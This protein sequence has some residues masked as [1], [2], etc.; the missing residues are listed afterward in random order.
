M[1]PGSERVRLNGTSGDG[2]SPGLMQTVVDRWADRLPVCF[3][4][5]AGEK[6]E[7]PAG[8]EDLVELVATWSES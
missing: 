8:N 3:G 2:P 1:N 7:I 6:V 4:I 5:G